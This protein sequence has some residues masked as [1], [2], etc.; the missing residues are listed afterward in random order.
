[1]LNVQNYNEIREYLVGNAIV[2]EGSSC[3]IEFLR[4]GVSNT[5]LKIGTERE[6]YVLKQALPRLNVKEDWFADVRRIITE[7]DCLKWLNHL[8]PGHVP[9]LI[10]ED[11]K[12]LIYIMEFISAPGTWKNHLLDGLLDF[13]VAEAVAKSLA[14]IHS[15]SANEPNIRDRFSNKEIFTQL[16]IN[17][18]YRHLKGK[19][20][21][22]NRIIDDV[23]E[24]CLA[25]S[26]CLVSGD[27][28]PKNI[29][30]DGPRITLLDFEVAHFGDPSF[31]IGFLLNHLLLKSVKNKRY[32]ESYLNMMV[33]VLEEY[34]RHTPNFSRKDLEESTIRQLALLFLAR[35][36]GKSP[37]EYITSEAD[38][39]WIRKFSY[40]VLE[41]NIK[42]LHELSQLY[43]QK[44]R[45]VNQ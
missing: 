13:R 17:P 43:E 14:A 10:H 11:E 34:F 8:V 27:F 30:V 9:Q 19:H 18:Y 29:L 26:Q 40:E 6:S 35:V 15:L 44:T 5:V 7:K 39:I 2:D 21:M 36:D 25:T 42:T 12:N 23:S 3:V 20:P 22:L 32:K 33:L 24:Q 16:R 31:D 45:S 37:A 38:R 1:M 28:S 4:G 41:S